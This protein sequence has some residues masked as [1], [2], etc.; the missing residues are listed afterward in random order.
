MPEGETAA[1]EPGTL[2][3]NCA[4]WPGSTQLD[5]RDPDLVVFTAAGLLEGN[6]RPIGAAVRLAPGQSPES[7]SVLAAVL[8]GIAETFTGILLVIPRFRR[9]GLVDP[10]PSC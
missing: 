3:R 1:G 5:L 10:A 4:A 2:R 9:C 6:V 7:L 8:F